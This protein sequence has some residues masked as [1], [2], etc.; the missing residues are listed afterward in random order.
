MFRLMMRRVRLN[1]IDRRRILA[2][3]ILLAVLAF[4]ALP[5]VSQAANRKLRGPGFSTIVPSNWKVTTSRKGGAHT[6]RMVPPHTKKGVTVNS[7]AIGVTVIPGKDV[8]RQAGHKISD[9]M[10]ELWGLMVTAPAGAQGLQIIAP[11][12][13]T[14]VDG[15]PGASGAASYF[16]NDASVLQSD[17]VTYRNGRVYVIEFATDINIQYKGLPVLGRL[18]D[19]WRW[20]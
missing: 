10:E 8:E 17:T 18:R 11:V 15:T 9:S 20:R 12:R 6:Y 1:T 7:M 14:T 2:C 16:F 13:T 5:S 3:S 4:G 19:H